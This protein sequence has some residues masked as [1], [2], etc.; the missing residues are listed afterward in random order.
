[1]KRGGAN[2]HQHIDNN[3]KLN[4]A[5]S[6][7]CSKTHTQHTNMARIVC[8]EEVFKQFTD[9]ASKKAY[10]RTWMEFMEF[11]PNANFEDGPPG[12]EY[13]TKYFTHL[14]NQKNMAS[15]TMWTMFSYINSVMQ[16]KYAVKL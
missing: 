11:S 1:M 7:L 3:T 13:L 9:E 6:Q 12:E 2:D 4:G 5:Y 8:D 16:R 14:Q 10:K 15:S